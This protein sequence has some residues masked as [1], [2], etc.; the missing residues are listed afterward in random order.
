MGRLVLAA[1]IAVCV[2]EFGVQAQT[3][4]QSGAAQTAMSIRASQCSSCHGQ[5]GDSPTASVPRL[6]GQSAAYL[7]ARLHS[8]RYPV[9]ESPRAIH[10]MGDIAPALRTD[11]IA[12]LANFYAGQKPPEWAPPPDAKEGMRLYRQGGKDI[13]AC[14]SCHGVR[15]QGFG[16]APRLAGQHAEY[17]ELQLQSFTMAARVADP[18]NHH[19]WLMTPEQA[20]ALAHY[21]GN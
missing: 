20:S 14:Q 1:L 2:L 15:S 13:P 17:L 12:A 8:L 4:S 16:E 21:L 19:V 18:M 6:N 7:Y 9:R 3:L 11:V 5:T 10:A